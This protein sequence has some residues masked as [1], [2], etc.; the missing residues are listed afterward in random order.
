MLPRTA[1]PDPDFMGLMPDYLEGV[2]LRSLAVIC[3]DLTAKRESFL[4]DAEHVAP[5]RL[6]IALTVAAVDRLTR[7]RGVITFT[8]LL[9]GERSAE[10]VV[11]TFLAMLEL[12]K[13]GSITVRQS[14][15]F[16][17][18]DVARVEGAPAFELDESALTSVGEEEY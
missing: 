5:R 18:I 15:I 1:G 3:A 4:L 17:E 9:Q 14:Q 2:S 10:A 12:F 13:R 6:P 8:E 16:G 7:L 11:A